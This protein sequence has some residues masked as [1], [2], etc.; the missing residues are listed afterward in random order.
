M[1]HCT[2]CG[3]ELMEGCAF[4]GSCGVHVGVQLVANTEYRIPWIGDI[5]ARQVH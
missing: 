3:R 2:R 1:A 4:C 5:V